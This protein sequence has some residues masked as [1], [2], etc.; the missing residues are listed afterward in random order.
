MTIKRLSC[1]EIGGIQVVNM[2]N[3]PDFGTRDGDIRIDRATLWG[4]PHVMRD[5]SDA[6]RDRVCD[7]Y[8]KSLEAALL[9][10]P[11]TLSG[12]MHAR[13]LGCWCAPKRCH[14]ET[15]ARAIVRARD[16]E[17]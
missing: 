7:A 8:Q 10:E 2:R 17:G 5:A 11:S 12:I 15:L 6:E 14:G 13:R 3:C 9:A 4:N 16:T 1:F